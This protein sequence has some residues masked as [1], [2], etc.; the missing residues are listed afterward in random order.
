MATVPGKP[1][2]INK[3]F[4]RSVQQFVTEGSELATIHRNLTERILKFGAK[5]RDLWNQAKKLDAGD[6]GIHGDYL[7]KELLKLIGSENKTIRS[8]WMTIG[9]QANK[10]LPFKDLLPPTR[11]ILAE[12]ARAKKDGKP[13][14]RWIEQDKLGY[15]SSVRD[16]R[17]LT[18]KKNRSAAANAQRYV[19]VTIRMDTTYGEAAK[20]F[21][22]LLKSPQVI[23]YNS[24][25]SFTNS[26]KHEM[27]EEFALIEH[28]DRY[29]E[30]KKKKNGKNGTIKR[31][32]A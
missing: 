4:S 22:D 7:R 2:S 32:A 18:R 14:E 5:F 1:D 6:H 3:A 30:V 12:L 20:L 29:L 15:D 19:T 8:Q 16:V 10:L 9:A 13:I 11:E 17:A 21:L 26:L 28:K 24:D 31:K 27:R 25:Q 23:H